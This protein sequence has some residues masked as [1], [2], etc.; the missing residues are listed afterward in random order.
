[1]VGEHK[2]SPG[3]KDPNM[4]NG[5]NGVLEKDLTKLR[6]KYASMKNRKLSDLPKPK[7]SYGGYDYYTEDEIQNSYGCNFITEKRMHLL[8]EELQNQ[9][10]VNETSFAEYDYLIKFLD[11]VI[12]RFRKLKKGE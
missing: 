9:I 3:K 4:L 12:E 8:I 10:K 11:D 7:V 5:I 1:M 6:N 2:N